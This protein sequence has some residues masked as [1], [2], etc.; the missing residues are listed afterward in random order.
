MSSVQ[1]GTSWARS[2]RAEAS[3]E[4]GAEYRPRKPGKTEALEH[5]ALR[6]HRKCGLQAGRCQMA[7]RT[8]TR[9]GTCSKSHHSL[10]PSWS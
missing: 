9:E 8:Q 3:E 1:A 6:Y 2:A 4:A 10:W 7:S 5:R